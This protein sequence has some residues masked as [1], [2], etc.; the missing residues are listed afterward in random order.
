MGE[1]EETVDQWL[2]GPEVRGD[3]GV[4]G[5]GENALN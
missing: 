4:F 1:S 3:G 2:P 5:G